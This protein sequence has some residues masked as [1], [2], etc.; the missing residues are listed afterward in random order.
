MKI[1]EIKFNKAV[2]D[3]ILSMMLLKEERDIRIQYRRR[4]RNTYL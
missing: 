3:K 4:I 2:V 1:N